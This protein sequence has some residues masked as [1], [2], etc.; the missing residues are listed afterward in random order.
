MDKWILA[1]LC[2]TVWILILFYTIAGSIFMTLGVNDWSIKFLPVFVVM[3]VVM[4][5]GAALCT[6]ATYKVWMEG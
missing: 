3:I 2:A 1:T 6:V 5:S 4:S